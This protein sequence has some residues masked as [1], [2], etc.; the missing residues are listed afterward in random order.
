M[1]LSNA[2][3]QRKYRE[4]RR[5][6]ESQKLVVLASELVSRATL[7]QKLGQSYGTA[8]DI[9]TALGYPKIL[10]FDHYYSRYKR[11]DIAKR[12]VNMP[13]I[14]TWRGKPVITENVDK[15]TEFENAWAKLVKSLNVYHYLT[16]VDKIAGIGQYAVLLMGFDD[17]H[18]LNQP[19]EKATKVLYLRPYN[20]NHA[21]INTWILDTKNERYG[22]P[23]TYRI[24]ISAGNKSNSVSQVVHHSRVLHVAEGLDEDD[25][26]GTPRLQ[27]VYN[28]LQDL[29]LIVGGSAEMFWRGAFPG[30]GFKASADANIDP[31]AMSALADEIDEYMHGL[32]RYL[33]L[34]G[35]DIENLAMQVA[36]PSNHVE[37]QLKLISGA[38]G[39]PVRI[40]TGSERGELASSQDETN[41]NARIDERRKDFAEPRILRPFIDRLIEIGILPEPKEGYTVEWPDIFALNEETKAKIGEIKTR[42]LAAY[43]NAPGA[44]M[45]V[46][47][48]IF[49]E[50]VLGFERE[51]I[52]KIREVAEKEL[53]E[54]AEEEETE[55]ESRNYNNGNRT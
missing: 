45:M 31:Q 39:I 4:K 38:T 46:P 5:S 32:K 16:R 25:I 14:A 17:G 18:P 33:R 23:E 13:A 43:V 1:A 53:R 10:T 19:V 28:R 15:E 44:D 48:E 54:E 34:Q 55:N 9:Y 52:D 49:L 7:A 35:I 3:R 22:L 47:I 42:S 2:E 30:Y 21:Q 50:E 20:E 24:T 29:E 51:K 8:R 40:L 37:V 11:Q 26:Y 6:A 41:W 27:A 12:I 36:D